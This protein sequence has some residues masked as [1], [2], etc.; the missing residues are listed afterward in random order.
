MNNIESGMDEVM[1]A[2]VLLTMKLKA[3]FQQPSKNWFCLKY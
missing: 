3:L 2:K 1:I